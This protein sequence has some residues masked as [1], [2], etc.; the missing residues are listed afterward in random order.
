MATHRRRPSFIGAGKLPTSL[1][2]KRTA[3]YAF[4]AVCRPNL[5]GSV[6]EG[7][8]AVPR[9]GEGHES[10][11][12]GLRPAGVERVMIGHIG[13]ATRHRLVAVFTLVRALRQE[14]V[15][16]LEA[17]FGDSLSLSP[18]TMTIRCDVRAADRGGATGEGLARIYRA[19]DRAELMT[20]TYR[21]DSLSVERL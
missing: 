17:E 6:P 18:S 10:P 14:C 11:F 5:A 4:P 12:S 3:P 9:W 20:D 16:Q 1:R 15:A 21:M 13:V 7:K 8:R 19:F 2:V